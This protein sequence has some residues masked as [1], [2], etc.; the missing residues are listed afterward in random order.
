MD[1]DILRQD[2]KGQPTAVDDDLDLQEFFKLFLK[3]IGFG[4]VVAGTAKDAIH[5]LRKQKFDLMFLDLQLPDVPGDQVY[6]TTKQIDPDQNV[7]F[8]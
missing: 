3:S 5:C 8:E 6:N 2:K 1:R 7:T 4:R